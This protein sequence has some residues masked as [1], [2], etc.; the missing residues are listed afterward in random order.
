MRATTLQ[1]WLL[2]AALYAALL[3]LAA[4]WTSDDLEVDEAEAVRAAVP[5]REPVRATSRPALLRGG[6]GDQ[7]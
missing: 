6:G 2:R 1:R 4:A 3:C 5:A 7:G